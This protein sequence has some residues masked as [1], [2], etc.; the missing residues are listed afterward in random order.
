MAEIIAPIQHVVVLMLENRSYDNV[1]GWLYG[2][3]NQAPYDKAPEG[4]SDLQGLTGTESNIDP[5]TGNAIMVQ[6][7]AP[8]TIG[9]SGQTYPATALPLIDPNETFGNMAQQYLGVAPGTGT[10]YDGYTTA[11]GVMT[12][13]LDNYGKAPA[14]T[15]NNI[16]DV[17]TYLTPAQL[18][19]TAFLANQFAVSDQ[20][21]ASVPTQTFTNRLF[22]FC[23]A[24]QV[25]QGSPDSSVVDDK[26]HSF[27]ALEL[28]PES[29]VVSLPSILSQLDTVLGTSAG[30]NWKLYFHDYSIAALILPYVSEKARSSTP[31]SNVS[32]FDNS[33][34]GSNIPLQLRAAA[35]STFVDDVQNGQLP[36]FS[37]I[38]PRYNFGL[39]ADPSPNDLPPNSNHPG[40]GNYGV[41]LLTGEPLQ[42][43][44]SDPPID[45]TGGE[46]LLMQ[47]YNL[48]R[49]SSLWESTLLI[50]TYDEAGGLYD[51]VGPQTATAP[52]V[53][54]VLSPKAKD[55]AAVDFGFNV[56]GGRVP[57]I[58]VSR[59]IAPGTTIRADNPISPAPPAYFDHSSIVKT[60]WDLFGLSQS[61][62]TIDSLTARD[63]SAPSL[64]P[65]IQFLPVNDAPPFAGTIVASP[66]ALILMSDRLYPSSLT[67]LASAGP[68]TTL[69]AAGTSITTYEDNGQNWLTVNPSTIQFAP[70]VFGWTISINTDALGFLG[71]A[72]LTGTVTITIEGTTTTKEVGVSLYLS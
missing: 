52:D 61:P 69:T 44:P 31:Q 54:A 66:S 49:T 48:L 68:G 32:T 58:I 56:Y 23:A 28:Y 70:D 12:G 71:S 51:H 59:H 17:M 39:L 50:V 72:F 1:L 8:N 2:S 29:D 64:A 67:L 5:I 34:W 43:D 55:T 57:A 9:G 53:P 6:N 26:D 60:V 47:V 24:P 62:F 22:A 11:D 36:P 65:F 15:E 19:V 4:Q 45:A 7:A 42:V 14:M 37:F 3:G 38:E 33:D 18:P 13:F 10:P 46:L 16:G 35:P 20:W 21:F 41:N 63:R 25:I 30:P 40:A 27:H